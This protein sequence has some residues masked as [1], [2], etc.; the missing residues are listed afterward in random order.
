MGKA[1]DYSP[2]LAE[3]HKI[4]PED[5]AGML[6]LPSVGNVF[7]VDP[8][9][10]SDSDSGTTRTSALATVGAAYDKLTADQDDVVVICG[11]TST[12]RTAETAVITWAKRRTHI[13]G[14]GPLRKVNPRNGIG[15]SYSGG[16]TTPV[17]KVTATNC[18]F[19]NISIAS[20]T[21]NDILVEVTAGNN[22]FNNVHFQGI[23][24]ATPAGETGARCLL[25]TGAGE[26]EFY[27]CVFGLDTVTRTAANATVEIT[28]SSAR[29]RF[30]GCDFVVFT[31]DAG[32]VHVK[33]DTGN[34]FERFLLFENCLFLNAD[35]DSSTA[36]TVNM[37]L[38]ATGNGTVFLK[39]SW[40]KGATDWTNTFSHL[41]VTMPLADTDEGGLTKIG[42]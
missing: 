27:N 14:N 40:S 15:A 32:V 5:L 8:G 21:D 13:V 37:D 17:F 18:S 38:S 10:G 26:N 11:S 29:N 23:G 30:V 34:A 1:R 6:G 16:S 20:F 9:T 4:Y 33:A 2:A 35:L 19:T 3:G 25:I 24:H 39:D 12:G 31:S 28:G 7:Y 42:T 22:T 41:F 36:L